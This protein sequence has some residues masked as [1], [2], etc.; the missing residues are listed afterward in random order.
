MRLV[1]FKHQHHQLFRIGSAAF[2][3]QWKNLFP[4]RLAQP[5]QNLVQRFDPRS[6]G[7]L[8][9]PVEFTAGFDSLGGNGLRHRLAQVGIESHRQFIN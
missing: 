3:N 1:A 9:R 7:F 6:A 5:P 8:T 2:R 4:A